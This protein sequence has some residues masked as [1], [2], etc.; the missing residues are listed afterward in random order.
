VKWKKVERTIY[1]A[2]IYFVQGGT[3]KELAK[4]LR[5]LRLRPD[6][7][8][9]KKAKERGQAL[10]WTLK[11]TTHD[12]KFAI[13]VWVKGC[14]RNARDVCIVAHE[15]LHATYYIF[16]YIGQRHGAVCYEDQE[17]HTYLHDYLVRK[18]LDFYWKPQ[19]NDVSF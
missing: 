18:A 19:L 8:I 14:K 13:L 17:C 5:R 10:G 16:E 3:P 6:E 15:C 2:D 1:P 12:G 9:E 4:K 11:M 7:D